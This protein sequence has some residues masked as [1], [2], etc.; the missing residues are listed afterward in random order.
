MKSQPKQQISPSILSAD[1]TVLADQIESV[2]EAGCQVLHL[3]VMDGQY[4]P[5]IS[6]GPM[7]VKAVRRTTDI[8][9]ESHLMISEPDQYLEAFAKAGSD[10][11]LVHPS[12]CPSVEKTLDDIHELGAKAGLVINPDEKLADVTPYLAKMDQLLIMS[13]FP[14]FGGQKFIPAVLNDLPEL[15]PAFSEHE[16]LIEIDG[17][18]NSETLPK[19]V[20]SGIQRFVA[21]SAVF[22]RTAT[23]AENYSRLADLLIQD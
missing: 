3:D 5:N 6:F 8:I 12:T 11:I 16:V 13:V 4:V 21:G 10:I 14:G 20:N 1:F 7:I 9:L 2:V 22:N 18:I 15:L 17:G 23:P 19:V